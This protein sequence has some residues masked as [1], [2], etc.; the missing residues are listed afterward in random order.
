MSKNFDDFVCIG[1]EA[2]ITCESDSGVMRWIELDNTDNSVL[3]NTQSSGSTTVGAFNVAVDSIEGQ[4][5]IATATVT[6]AEGFF[7]GTFMDCLDAVVNPNKERATIY[8]PG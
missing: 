3:L 1:N 2:R 4:V 5:I 6:I 8:V 7:N